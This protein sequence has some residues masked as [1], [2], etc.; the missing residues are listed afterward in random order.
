M[1]EDGGFDPAFDFR[2]EGGDDPDSEQSDAQGV[3]QAPV[4]QAL[5]ER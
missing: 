5:A 3:P 2:S 4:E 1:G